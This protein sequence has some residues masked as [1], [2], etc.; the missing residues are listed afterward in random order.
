MTKPPATVATATMIEDRQ[1]SMTTVIALLGISLRIIQEAPHLIEALR[2][3]WDGVI[4]TEEPHDT[5]VAAI[6][7]AFG[8]SAE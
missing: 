1:M 3:F 5:V 7:A 2:E 8:K 6:N 4:A